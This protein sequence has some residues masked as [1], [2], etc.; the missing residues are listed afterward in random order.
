[1]EKESKSPAGRKTTEVEYEERMVRVFELMLYERLNS[2]EF[3]NKASKE[4]GITT[5]QADS[6][7]KDAKDRLKL[8]F[9]DEREELLS[10]Q[11]ERYFDLLNRCR[12][13]NNR[14]V[15]KEVLDSLTKLFGLENTQKLDITSA[16]EPVSINIILDK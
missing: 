16:G 14:R 5:R 15:E 7:W 11:I 1:M 8:R 9:E 3:R 12:D 10:S 2:I 13:S 6:L 4:F